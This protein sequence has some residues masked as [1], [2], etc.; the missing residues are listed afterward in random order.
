MYSF[1]SPDPQTASKSTRDQD[2]SR[3]TKF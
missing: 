2:A 1:S 3:Y